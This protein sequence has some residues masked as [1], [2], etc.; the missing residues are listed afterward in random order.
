[1]NKY[2][3]C[4]GIGGMFCVSGKVGGKRKNNPR[5]EVKKVVHIISCNV[6]LRKGQKKSSS[7]DFGATL[8]IRAVLQNK[9]SAL[10]IGN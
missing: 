10:R 2:I 8:S 6:K 3:E 9:D 4:Q 7:H 1:M 5:L